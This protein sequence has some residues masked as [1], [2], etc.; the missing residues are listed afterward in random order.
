MWTEGESA[1]RP[2]HQK[3]RSGLV[4]SQFSAQ[5]A[6]QTRRDTSSGGTWGEEELR[7]KALSTPGSL[8]EAGRHLVFMGR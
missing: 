4:C 1:L 2:L 3:P 6:S 5:P 7:S 8:S